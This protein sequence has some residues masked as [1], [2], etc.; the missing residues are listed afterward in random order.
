MRIVF[1]SEDGGILKKP[2]LERMVE[3]FAPKTRFDEDEDTEGCVWH[4]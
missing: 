3:I 4:E 1:E 2:A